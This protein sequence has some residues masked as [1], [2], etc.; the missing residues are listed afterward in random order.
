MT[1]KGH[2]C[3]FGAGT[4]INAIATWKGAAFGIDLK[5][6]AE[7]KLSEGELVI[8]GSIEEMPE[9]DTRLIEH[10]VELVLERFGLELGGTIRTGSEIPLAGGLKSSSAAANASVLATLRLSG[11]QCP[12]LR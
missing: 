10:C 11:R 8:T 3:A 7:V 12:L 4:I 2:A 9:G 1:L 5:T 6:F